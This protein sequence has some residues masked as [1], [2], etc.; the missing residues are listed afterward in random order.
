M[1]V[2]RRSDAQ[3]MT[4]QELRAARRV[5]R[6]KTLRRAPGPMQEEFAQRYHIPLGTLR[7]WGQWRTGPE[8]PPAPISKRLQATPKPFGARLNS[9]ALCLA[10]QTALSPS[11]AAGS[12]IESW[13][14]PGRSGDLPFRSLK[15][16]PARQFFADLVWDSTMQELKIGQLITLL[17]YHGISPYSVNNYPGVCRLGGMPAARLSRHVCFWPRR[18][19]LSGSGS[20]YIALQQLRSGFSLVHAGGR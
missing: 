18:R 16:A 1:T 2:S 13:T 3:P 12:L 8:G 7:D 5:P 20:G 10:K 9:D 17:N 4:A 14:S 15:R 19:L 6:V 11:P